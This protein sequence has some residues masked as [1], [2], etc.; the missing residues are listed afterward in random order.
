MKELPISH[1]KL[2]LATPAQSQLCVVMY[3]SDG[4]KIFTAD[5]RKTLPAFVQCCFEF[6]E[7]WQINDSSGWGGTGHMRGG[8]FEENS[9]AI[10][11]EAD[12]YW[13][14]WLTERLKDTQT[15]PSHKYSE[16]NDQFLQLNR[17]LNYFFSLCSRQTWS[18][19]RNSPRKERLLP[20]VLNVSHLQHFELRFREMNSLVGGCC[21]HSHC[22]FVPAFS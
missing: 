21:W 5:R 1:H 10:N 8:W 14:C 19:L 2:L 20:S 3:V 11:E 17:W 9:V 12:L 15:F 6:T 16:A 22:W 7:K 18:D 13:W 4:R